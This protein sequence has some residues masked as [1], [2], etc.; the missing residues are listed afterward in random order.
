MRIVVI[1]SA[2]I[3]TV[4]RVEDSEFENPDQIEL[5]DEDILRALGGKGANQAVSAVL[6]SEEQKIKYTLLVALAKMKQVLKY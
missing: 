2:N 5:K 1:G 4:Y 3:D 6:Q